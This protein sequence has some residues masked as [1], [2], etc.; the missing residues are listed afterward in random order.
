MERDLGISL[1]S[2]NELH[3]ASADLTGQVRRR[4]KVSVAREEEGSQLTGW[5][6]THAP[7]CY[8]ICRSLNY[9]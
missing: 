3:E 9:C 7:L 1:S 2:M 6:Y 5:W 8:V 4:Y